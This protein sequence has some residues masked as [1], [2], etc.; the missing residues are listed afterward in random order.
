MATGYIQRYF[1]L[2]MNSGDMPLT[3]NGIFT[4][5]M[6]IKADP[7]NLQPVYVGNIYENGENGVLLP[8]G[9]NNNLNTLNPGQSE[10]YA[11]IVQNDR[12]PRTRNFYIE[13]NYL[14]VMPQWYVKGSV[15]DIVFVY[16]ADE[17][18][19]FF[20]INSQTQIDVSTAGLS[21]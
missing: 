14:H 11:N 20:D 13:M 9:P 1:V 4:P 18:N 6:T 8:L 10:D 2:T 15:G 19:G 16:W 17:G 21:R 12:L 3:L 7:N 5:R